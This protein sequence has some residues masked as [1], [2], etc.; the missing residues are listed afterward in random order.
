MAVHS[1]H[2]L[3]QVH[4]DRFLSI[5]SFTALCVKQLKERILVLL[6]GQV[7]HWILECLKRSRCT[8]LV[9][10]AVT[11]RSIHPVYGQGS[12]ISTHKGEHYE[13][14]S[15]SFDQDKYVTK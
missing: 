7:T 2:R 4:A 6:F 10:H 12:S 11:L 1:A 15:K 14:G 5:V 13:E 9:S 8:T 3:R